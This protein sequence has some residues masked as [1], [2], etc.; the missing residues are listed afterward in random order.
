LIFAICFEAFAGWPSGVSAAAALSFCFLV[1]IV[2]QS[3]FRRCGSINAIPLY[4]LRRR[5][6]RS[7]GRTTDT[8]AAVSGVGAAPAWD[9]AGSSPRRHRSSR[10]RVGRAESRS[11]RGWKAWSPT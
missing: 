11:S 10:G 7:D 2:V 1:A 8:C 4:R 6:R 9:R 5:G 3:S